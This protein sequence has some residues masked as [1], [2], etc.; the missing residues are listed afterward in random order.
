MYAIGRQTV[1][2]MGGGTVMGKRRAVLGRTVGS[3]GSDLLSMRYYQVSQE[4]Q[5]SSKRECP[6]LCV[7]LPPPDPLI[8][9]LS[10]VYMNEDT[11]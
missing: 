2:C 11:G 6:R 8:I 7:I 3:F 10:S 5:K 1:G 9:L 4:D